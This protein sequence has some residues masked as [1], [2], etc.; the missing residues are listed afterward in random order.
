MRLLLLEHRSAFAE[1]LA[2]ALSVGG[3]AVCECD[4]LSAYERRVASGQPQPFDAVVL[5]LRRESNH[6]LPLCR[7][8][9]RLSHKLPVIAVTATDDC[10]EAVR[11]VQ[12]G[13]EDVCLRHEFAPDT[14]RARIRCAVE[15]HRIHSMMA[16]EVR[17]PVAVGCEA[18]PD[19]LAPFGS[20]GTWEYAVTE[21]GNLLRLACV[22]ARSSLSGTLR[23]PLWT[24][25][26][27]LPVEV[28]HTN[29]VPALV[30]HV[31]QAHVDGVVMY[32]SELDEDALDAISTIKVHRENS[33]ILLSA[34][35]P[36]GDLAVEA[37][38]YGADDCLDPEDA[39]HRNIS[40]YLRQ[41]LARRKRHSGQDL[42]AF[43]EAC[44]LPRL[45]QRNSHYQQRSPRYFVTKSAIAIPI[46]PDMTPDESLRAEGFTVDVSESG[47]GFEIG[48]LCELPSELLLAG[49]EGDDGT[50][51]FATV[52][53]RNWAPKQ[54]RTHVGAQFLSGERDLLREE[55]LTPTYHAD[56]HEFAT[57]LPCDTLMKWVELGVLRPLLV[58]RIYVCPKCGAMP[59]FRS[60]CRS[61]GSIHVASHQLIH[62]FDCSYL[63]MVREFESDGQINCPKCG[64]RELVAGTDFEQ[65]S[66]PCHCLE[67]NWSDTTTEVVGQCLRCKWHFPLKNA[68]EQDLTGYHVHRLNPQSLLGIS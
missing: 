11:M 26:L 14:L 13:A 44:G 56:R 3:Q 64:A 42:D 24:E 25:A 57:A 46:R 58:D 18:M 32:L 20:G 50:L 16:R 53:V 10:D 34:P 39:T 1:R 28:T 23:D 38:R 31:T 6:I 7:Q 55:N 47:I 5:D 19:A 45:P 48:A 51:Y 54:G 61:C 17:I 37:I 36:D 22:T 40:R 30:H 49:I 52:E 29:C 35:D 33:V 12:A 59:T 60:G 4:T 15:R 68:S 9:V 63:G 43:N 41:G 62:H 66:G 67:C 27:G 2:A 65:L 21:E 8:V